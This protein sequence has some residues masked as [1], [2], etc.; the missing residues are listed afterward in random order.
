MAEQKLQVLQFRPGV[1]REGT[2]YS[3]EGGWYACDKIRFRSGLPE[4][5]GGW[6]TY[7]SGEYLGTC[8]HYAE[9]VSLTSYYLLAV[10]TNLKYYILTGNKYYDITPIRV[11]NDPLSNNPF[12]PIYGSL[13]ADISASDTTITVSSGTTFTRVT[14]YV[15]TIGAEDIYVG[16]AAGV[17]LSNCVR[18]YNG[19]TAST[20]SS[21]A[22]IA[23]KWLVLQDSANGAS[24]NDFVT[25][26]NATSFGPYTP[27]STYLNIEYQIKAANSGY[28]AFDT[29]VLSTSTTNGGGAVVSAAY[30]ITTGSASTIT[31]GGWGAG[32]WPAA[33]LSSGSSTLSST[34]S[35]TTTS[36]TLASTS[37]FAA[38]GYVLID[39][40]L[41]A[42][43]AI[44]GSTLTVSARGA[45]GTSATGHMA[46]I[47]VNG[48]TYT[49]ATRG[50]NTGYTV[51][52]IESAL[53]LWSASNYGQ[54]LFFN[55]RNGGIYFW[56]ASTS[57][58]AGGSVTGRGIDI[59]S[60]TFSDV[61]AGFIVVGNYYKIR[62][63]GST[64]FVAIG[65]SSN[66][67]GVEFVAT[68][69][70]TG[71]GVVY[72]PATPS[73]AACVVATDERHVIAYGCNDYITTG[74]LQDPMYIA[75]CEQEQ[76][77]V[78]YPTATNTA[79]SYRLTYGSRI[80]T[81]VRTR[82]EILVFTDTALYSQQYLGAP[83]IYGFNQISVDITIVSPNAATT[84]NGVTYWMGQ[85]K[86]YMYSGRVD[87]LP[88]AL[89]QYVFDDINT[90]QWDQVYCGT[91]EKYNEVWWLYPSAGSSINDRYVVYNY[92]ENLW[93]YG[94]IERTAWFDSHIIGNPIA[95]TGNITVQHESG[96]DDGSVNPPQAIDAY[97][98]TSDFDIGE[99]GYQYSFVKR[100]IPD[101]DFIGS[102]T[103]TP[104]V[105]MTLTARDYP[106]QPYAGTSSKQN[107]P[108]TVNGTDYSTQ[109]YGYTEQV[110]I[111]LRGRQLVFR[112][113]SDQLGTR[114]QL[115]N[116]RIEIQPDGRR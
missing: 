16:S 48:A 70:G 27:A 108:A 21:S 113:E 8:R 114:W 116:P 74:P 103:T 59:T 72:D 66:T 7:G 42:Y 51:S 62:T 5:L 60:T 56:D 38:S 76:P 37:G 107:A 58:S 15:I 86:F 97:I 112:V 14:P 87:T 65:A 18:G 23:S 31:L 89:R 73:V 44:V 24:V 68:G 2:S 79:G 63:V 52:G 43:S 35:S 10:G 80:V 61:G 67:V 39:A 75:W 32:P 98:E 99:G 69:V 22:T 115:G 90:S 53:R 94:T 110:W 64:N 82:Q 28:I 105:T 55:P 6:V 40:E 17:T 54:N 41:I 84:T 96:A 49:A 78:W 102:A 71:T 25:F 19:T 77:Q 106:G 47:A 29:G 34:I 4:K 9:W 100:L 50:W 101:I 109:V 3:G 45:A 46:G 26:S 30:Q 111:R 11:V 36:I 33:V 85:D 95:A 91:N 13:A 104:T 20:H 12:Y 92:L 93:F 88:C 1:N 57:L 81:A 83:Y